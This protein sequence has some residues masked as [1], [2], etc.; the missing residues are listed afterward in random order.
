[1]PKTRKARPRRP[2]TVAFTVLTPESQPAMYERLYSLLSRYHD[3]LEHARIC[4]AW[5]TS[6]RLDLDGH[7]VL[8]RCKRA[9]EL[10][11]ELVEW[12]FVI[13]LNRE[14][15]EH[16]DTTP[17]QR[18]ALLDHEL[19]HATVKCDPVTNEPMR[20]ERGRIVYRLRKHDVEEFAVIPQRHG[21]WKR[22]IERFA[23]VCAAKLQNPKLPLDRTGDEPTLGSSAIN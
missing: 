21:L 11:R 7:I 10:D 5:C 1:M 22:D 13:L 20:N 12:D 3:D 19:Q 8:G 14:F 18:D 23:Q 15:W 2:P 9:S 16:E 17:Q 4:L 6:W